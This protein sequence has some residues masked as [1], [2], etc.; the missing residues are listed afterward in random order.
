MH[1]LWIDTNK[2]HI[3]YHFI[4]SS[5][6]KNFY[7]THQGNH[8][9]AIVA[10]EDEFAATK[11]DQYSAGELKF[12]LYFEAFINFLEPLDKA[13]R[14]KVFP[15]LLNNKNFLGAIT[16]S[17]ET[18]SQFENSFPELKIFFLP[19]GVPKQDEE[20]VLNKINILK[21]KEPHFLFISSWNDVNNGNYFG[22]GGL[23]ADEIFFRIRQQINCKLTIRS[24]DVTKS[25]KHFP[26]SVSRYVSYISDEEM[27]TQFVNANVFLL[28][29]V[30]AHF[31]CVPQAASH[32]MFIIGNTQFGFCDYI[33]DGVN[34]ISKENKTYVINPAHSAYV[35]QLDES[36]I[37]STVESFLEIYNEKDKFI[38]CCNN[39]FYGQI[40]KNCMENYGSNL[41]SILSQCYS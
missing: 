20:Y 41:D 28:P 9:I 18:K 8:D 26:E 14:N 12:F 2:N 1:K 35:D 25:E 6:G 5:S 27:N 30:Q 39:S 33:I 29:S 31:V 23:Y 19:V 3:L 22:R 24:N 13:D 17:S 38:K 37:N 32:G 16:H 10:L 15:Q 4:R 36:Y 21:E 34:G 40:E 7:F 11:I